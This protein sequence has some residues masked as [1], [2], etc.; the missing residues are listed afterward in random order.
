MLD[1]KLFN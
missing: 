1:A